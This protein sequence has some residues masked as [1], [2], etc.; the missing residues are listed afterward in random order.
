[1]KCYSVITSFA[2]I[3]LGKIE[4]E[5]ELLIFLPFS[6]RVMVRL[7]RVIVV[8]PGHIHLLFN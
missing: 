5:L 7:Q 1:M 2:I 4:R 3:S 8:F 6:Q